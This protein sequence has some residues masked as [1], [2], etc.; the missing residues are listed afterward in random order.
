MTTAKEY[1]LSHKMRQEFGIPDNV[2]EIPDDVI[3]RFFK[4]HI[5]KDAYVNREIMLMSM[6]ECIAID[7]EAKSHADKKHY[8]IKK[9]LLDAIRNMLGIKYPFKIGKNII[10]KK[11]FS[12]V[13]KVIKENEKLLKELEFPISAKWHKNP[14]LTIKKILQWSLDLRA[15][16]KVGTKNGTKKEQKEIVEHYKSAK[17]FQD[18][19][20]IG[21]WTKELSSHTKRYKFCREDI[22]NKPFKELTPEQRQYYIAITPHIEVEKWKY[23]W[24]G[25]NIDGEKFSP[26]IEVFEKKF[27]QQGTKLAQQDFGEQQ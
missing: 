14:I 5:L 20:G 7:D 11:D 12:T 6:S 26:N 2:V 9:V 25:K 8:V 21:V 23:D 22:S 10:F 18:A 1:E 15:D 3:E 4:L 16:Y 24:Q 19:L 13:V 27:S 17:I